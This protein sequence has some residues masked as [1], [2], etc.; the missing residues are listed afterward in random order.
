MTKRVQ[1]I[2]TLSMSDTPYNHVEIEK[3]WQKKWSDEGAFT[4]P[5]IPAKPKAYVLDMFPYP[6]GEGL[7]VGH[8]K[9]YIATDIYS[10]MKMMQGYDVLHPMGWDAFG[11]PAENYAIKNKVHPRVAVEKNIARFKEQLSKIG[12]TYDWDREINTTDPE[13]YKWTQWIFLQLYKKGLAYESFEPINW[14]PSCQTGLANEDLEGGICERCGSVAEKRP[15]RQWVLK[16]TDYAEKLLAGLESLPWPKSITESQKNWI[17]KSVGVD[18]KCRIKDLNID[19]S[20]YDSV[21]QTYFAQTFTV[22][23]PEHPLVEELVRGTEHEQSVLEFVERIKQ[24]KAGNRFDSEKDIEGIFTGRYIENFADTGRDLPIW[25]ASFVLADYGTGIV[26]ASAHDERDFAF[27][28]KYNIPLH[29]VMLPA[30][31]AHAEKVRNLEEGYYKAPEGIIQEPEQFRGRKWQEVRE[32]VIDHLVGSGFAERSVHY[33]LRDWVFSRQRYWGEPIPIIHCAKDG[34]VPVPEDQL[35]VLLPEV[36]KYE[37]TGTGESPLAAIPEFVN[38][39]CPI[40]SGPA[41]RETN[42]MPQW[43]G[44]SWYYLRF[45]DSANAKEF[46]DSKKEQS[47]MN[48]DLYVGGAEHATR[49]LI[50]ARFW[51]IVLHELG[52]VST[53]EPFERLEHVGLILAEDGRK[54]SKRWG[55]VINPDDVVAS[56]G[57]DT[58]RIYEMFMGPFHQSVQWSTAGI[59]G[60]RRFIERVWKLQQKVAEQA[61]SAEVVSALHQTILRVSDDTQN[62]RFNTAIAGMME[63]LN[64]LEKEKSISKKTFETLLLLL[65]PYAPHVCEELWECIGN[66]GMISHQ[67]WPAYNA[68]LAVEKTVSIAVQVNG[69]VRGELVVAPNASQEEVEMLAKGLANIAK[70]MSGKEIR[71]VIYVQGKLISFVCA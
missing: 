23:A 65:A 68:T 40:C 3:K 11:L 58:L 39:T 46:V 54:M 64:V 6:S 20:M 69:K 70:H 4:T 18:L 41:T 32:D 36:E 14:C 44:S 59:S 2:Y 53:A 24:K 45:I 61:D 25:V 9:G 16:I 27:A 57:A 7:H 34:V 50:Y 28:K 63:L 33:K 35:P 31:T 56:F 67:A 47:W 43:A 38:T 21:P 17:G 60:P 22:I 62:F 15:M 26:N 19:V 10:R 42:T 30:D 12:F 71:K 29:P 66:V 1:Y 13:Y 49:H 52:L 37:P 48:V 55:N 8:P 51:H 5:D